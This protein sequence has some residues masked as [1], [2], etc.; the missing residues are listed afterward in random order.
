[1]LVHILLVYFII[2]T[3]VVLELI[4]LEIH[5]SRLPLFKS[6]TDLHNITSQK[7]D[8]AQEPIINGIPCAID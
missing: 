5:L 8:N 7:R 4:Y 1:M 6:Q 3:C 2:Q